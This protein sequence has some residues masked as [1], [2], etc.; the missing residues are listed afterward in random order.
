MLIEVEVAQL[1]KEEVSSRNLEGLIKPW[2][3]LLT[4]KIENS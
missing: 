2:L 4:S 3:K 1:K